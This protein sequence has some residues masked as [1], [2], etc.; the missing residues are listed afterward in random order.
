[1]AEPDYAHQDEHPPPD[2]V[3]HDPSLSSDPAE[4]DRSAR[5]GMVFLG[6]FTVAAGVALGLLGY[7]GTVRS[8]YVPVTG[9]LLTLGVLAF[10]N[11]ARM[12]ISGR[13]DVDDADRPG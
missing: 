5:R 9:V 11:A 7:T 10:V 12:R 13:P 3:P 2:E 1:M 8:W 6:M 4:R